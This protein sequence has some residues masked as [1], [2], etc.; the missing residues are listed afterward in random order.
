[1][2]RNR[3]DGLEAVVAAAVLIQPQPL[4]LLRARLLL[5]AVVLRRLP[6]VADSAYKSMGCLS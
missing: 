1:M 3:R 4:L 5:V 2:L 6:V